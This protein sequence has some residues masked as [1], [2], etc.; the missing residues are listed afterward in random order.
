MAR[1]ASPKRTLRRD[2]KARERNKS[3]KSTMKTFV[4]KFQT[5]LASGT[6]DEE[7]FRKAQSLIARASRKRLIH[8]GKGSR[9]ISRMMTKKVAIES[10]A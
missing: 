10:V 7:A 2:I 8:P 1:P 5:S 6:P 3:Q 4:K 9:M